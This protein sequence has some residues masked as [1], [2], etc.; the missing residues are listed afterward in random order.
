MTHTD[1]ATV[2]TMTTI[3]ARMSLVAANA[4]L[5]AIACPSQQPPAAKPSSKPK[6]PAA[7]QKHEGSHPLTNQKLGMQFA[8]LSS[9]VRRS[10][11][12]TKT[13][14]GFAVRSVT[15]GSLADLAGIK[16]GTVVLEVD[17]K[18]LRQVAQLEA[19]L[20]KAKPGQKITCKCS[21]RTKK[22]RLFRS[23][24]T[25]RDVRLQLPAKAQPKQ[26]KKKQ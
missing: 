2:R 3:R 15:K 7:D 5:L 11:I 1:P 14:Y 20:K 4:L 16:K 8:E 10:I 25:Q 13:P 18:P 21:D 17:G 6:V 9:K 22:R 23:P 19:V 24:W 26:P 12:R